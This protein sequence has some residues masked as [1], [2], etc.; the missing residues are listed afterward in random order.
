MPLWIGDYLAD[1]GRLTTE[2][3]GAFLLLL[4]D[5]WRSG[6][7]QDDN[8][9]L[10]QIT[11][12]PLSTWKKHRPVLKPFFRIADGLWHNKRLDQERA[13]AI[14]NKAMVTERAKRAAAARWGSGDA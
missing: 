13:K 5:Y 1:T 2:Q 9:V 7:P 3:H 4:M 11:K 14:E 10:A 12:L 6:P 8:T